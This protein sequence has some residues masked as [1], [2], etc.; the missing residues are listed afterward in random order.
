M[1]QT[2][3]CFMPERETEVA[4]M[5]CCDIL[6]A[7]RNE[8]NFESGT[9][10][11]MEGISVYDKCSIRWEP[12]ILLL[13]STALRNT[14]TKLGYSAGNKPF[15]PNHKTKALLLQR[16]PYCQ[17]ESRA[18]VLLCTQ[19]GK[20]VHFVQG[21]FRWNS[22]PR[23]AAKEEGKNDSYFRVHLPFCNRI[24]QEQKGKD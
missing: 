21:V 10:E 15:A 18:I 19:R 4:A 24:L 20:W 7:L 22:A 23:M 14:S 11:I 13:S 1:L 9:D 12:S 17:N 8:S 2:I 5:N 6:I 3:D 16:K